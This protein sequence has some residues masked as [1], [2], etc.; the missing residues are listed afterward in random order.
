MSECGSC[1][2]GEAYHIPIQLICKD[3]GK[4]INGIDVHKDRYIPF[5]IMLN[6]MECAAPIKTAVFY[7]R[8]GYLTA[9]FVQ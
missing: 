5:I 3:C 1:E 8:E 9:R 6:C 2:S 4:L 7:D